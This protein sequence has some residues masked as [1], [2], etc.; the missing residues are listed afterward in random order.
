MMNKSV[1]ITVIAIEK[2][3]LAN[4]T[5]KKIKHTII[6]QNNSACKMVLHG[7]ISIETI[8]RWL[9]LGAKTDKEREIYYGRSRPRGLHN[10]C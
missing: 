8:R 6:K 7:D 5:E 1:V 3:S 10:T 9:G 4:S 2:L